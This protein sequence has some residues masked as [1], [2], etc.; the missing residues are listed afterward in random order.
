MTARGRHPMQ[1]VYARCCGLDV[2]Q[3]TVV[4]C[5]LLTTTQGAVRREV[6]TFGTMTADL[7]ALND[8]LNGLD[9]EQ[10]AMESTGIYWRPVFSLLEA[11]HPI[12]L[13]N[14][15]HIKAVPGRKTDVKDSEWVA[16]LLRHGLL[17]ASFIPPQ[18]IRELRELT[19][20]RKTLVQERAQEAN[21]LHKVL[22]SANVKLAVVATDILGTSGRDML[23]AMLAGE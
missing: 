10:V 17:K 7:L 23:A 4:A 13:V 21:R 9:V 2:H 14:A 22:E 12:I 3:K 20:Y 1:V 18:P 6:R 15:Q 11:D 19:R 8:W 16:D 5:V